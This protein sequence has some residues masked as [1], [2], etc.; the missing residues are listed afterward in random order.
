MVLGRGNGIFYYVN[1]SN[2][3]GDGGIRIKIFL[4]IRKLT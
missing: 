3:N 1:D 4:V 2:D